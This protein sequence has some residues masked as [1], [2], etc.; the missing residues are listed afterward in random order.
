MCVRYI[1]FVITM[2]GDKRPIH[3]RVT[4]AS[5]TPALRGG[6]RVNTS[7]SPSLTV[8]LHFPGIEV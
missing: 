4:R 1:V 8:P 5:L 6:G 3:A 7:Q 2:T